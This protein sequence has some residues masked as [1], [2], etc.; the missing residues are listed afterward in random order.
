MLYLRLYKYEDLGF[1]GFRA[2]EGLMNF[3]V[4]CLGLLLCQ[5]VA[6]RACGG[7]VTC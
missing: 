5:Q 7:A 3:C 1:Y 2:Y 6:T 4:E